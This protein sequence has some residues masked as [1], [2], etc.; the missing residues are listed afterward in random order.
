[1]T[2][3]KDNTQ[4]IIKIENKFWTAM[5]S[6]DKDYVAAYKKKEWK[7][8]GTSFASSIALLGYGGFAFLGDTISMGHMGSAPDY[9]MVEYWPMFLGASAGLL[10][11]I[12]PIYLHLSNFVQSQVWLVQ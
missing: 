11:H 8:A 12:F 2:I 1:M 10:V 4:Y 6:E 9:M 7:K 3:E 5:R